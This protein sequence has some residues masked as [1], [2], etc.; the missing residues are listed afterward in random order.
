MGLAGLFKRKKI[1]ISIPLNSKKNMLSK[2]NQFYI[3]LAIQIFQ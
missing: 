2:K 1:V 3:L